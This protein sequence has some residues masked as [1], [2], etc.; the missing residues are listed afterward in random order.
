M[1]PSMDEINQIMKIMD[2]NGD[3]IIE[4]SE[5]LSTMQNWLEEEGESSKDSF[6]GS[7]R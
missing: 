5:F 2:Q 3:G 7:Q 1:K 4:L 6:I